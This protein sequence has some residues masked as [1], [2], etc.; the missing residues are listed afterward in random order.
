MSPRYAIRPHKAIF[1]GKMSLLERRICDI[2][3]REFARSPETF[4][5][6]N[7]NRIDDWYDLCNTCLEKV[8]KYLKLVKVKN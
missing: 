5:C 4:K 8:K 6:I 2:C 1:G 3:R 7:Y